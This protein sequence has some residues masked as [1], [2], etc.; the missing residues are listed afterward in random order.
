MTK[1]KL[2]KTLQSPNY[3]RKQ[4]NLKSCSQ[5]KFKNETEYAHSED[6][7]VHFR[8]FSEGQ[9]PSSLSDIRI[10]NLYT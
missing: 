8:I 10:L 4:D 3:L 5:C 6:L 9:V 7:A 1:M 2:E